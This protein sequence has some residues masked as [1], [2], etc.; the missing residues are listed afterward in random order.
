MATHSSILSWKIPW[1]EEP[2]RLQSMGS[3]RVG[4]GCD[5]TFT[6]SLF[7]EGS[8]LSFHLPTFLSSLGSQINGQNL[9]IFLTWVLSQDT[10]YFCIHTFHKSY[11]IICKIVIFLFTQPY[12]TVGQ[13]EQGFY[14]PYSTLYFQY[15]AGCLQH[16]KHSVKII[17]LLYF[18]HQ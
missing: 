14:N 9:R 16:N 3:Q 15:L 13:R 1:T 7:L 5:F 10:S 6:F 2:D 11:E 12:L 18:I 8:F 4:H 17:E